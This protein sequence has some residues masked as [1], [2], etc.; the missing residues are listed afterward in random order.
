MSHPTASLGRLFGPLLGL[1]F[2]ALTACD[3][4]VVQQTPAPQAPAPVAT[5]SGGTFTT[6]QAQRAF[7]TVKN[8]VEPIAER[9]CKAMT[10]NL[11]CDYRILVDDRPDQPP[12]A[13]QTLDE[14]RRPLIVFTLPLIEGARNAD[15]IA[16]IM[17]HEAAHHIEGHLDRQQQNAVA[18]AVIFAGLATLSGG[19]PN[20]VETATRLGAQVGAR[21]YSKEY[22]LEADR[23]GTV[24][25]IKAGYDPV[26]GAQYFNRIPD[27]G[28]KFLGTH[29][30]NSQRLQTV[31]ATAARY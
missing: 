15:E 8:R 28:N 23:L 3:E 17:G 4:V 1:A 21:S 5:G 2:L 18:G 12:N 30:P 13:F 25:T 9:E 6:A 26:L 16:F 11:N 31:R 19:D 7:V 29:P 22:E 14:N 20:A 27:P 24:L 10:R